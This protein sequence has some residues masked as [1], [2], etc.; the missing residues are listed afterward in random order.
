MDCTVSLVFYADTLYISSN[1]FLI[2]GRSLKSD[3]L[4]GTKL[5][6]PP[7]LLSHVAFQHIVMT[8]IVFQ[9]CNGGTLAFSVHSPVALRGTERH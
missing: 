4:D 2:N 7:F 9:E 1:T 6:S 3:I 5:K 8:V